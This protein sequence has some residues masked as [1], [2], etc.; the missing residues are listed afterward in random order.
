[1]YNVIYTRYASKIFVSWRSY[2]QGIFKKFA[3]KSAYL[4]PKRNSSNSPVKPQPT[5]KPFGGKTPGG[6]AGG[7]AYAYGTKKHEP[8]RPIDMLGFANFVRFL[9]E[10]ILSLQVYQLYGQCL[11]KAESAGVTWKVVNLVFEENGLWALHFHHDAEKVYLPAVN[12]H[13]IHAVYETVLSHQKHC[14]ALID[15]FLKSLADDN[16]MVTAQYR[17]QMGRLMTSLTAILKTENMD[18]AR[19]VKMNLR[20]A[21]TIL[22]EILTETWNMISHQSSFDPRSLVLPPQDP[23]SVFIDNEFIH[24]FDLV[25]QLMRSRNVPSR[26]V[27]SLQILPG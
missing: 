27:A 15:P 24:L 22:R 8:D 11:L 4:P 26:A 3:V 5:T 7:S 9:D 10:K 2:V 16:H 23:T 18:H 17:E 1:M 20:A 6:A 12:V 13:E 21:V 25:Y 19:L 14:V